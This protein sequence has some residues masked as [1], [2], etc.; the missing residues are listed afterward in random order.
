MGLYKRAHIRGMV[1]ELMRQEIVSFPSKEAADDAADRIADDFEEEEIP[2]VSGE[3]GLSPEQAQ[4]A[5][6]RIVEVAEEIAEKTSGAVDKELNKT[7]AATSY[8]DAAANAGWALIEKAAEETGVATGPD[9][10]GQTAPAPDLGA[11]AEAKQDAANV[12]SADLVGPQGTSDVDTRPGAVGAEEEQ[13]EQPGAQESQPTGEVAK[14]SGESTP[15]ELESLDSMLQKMAAETLKGNKE[16]MDGASLTGG[17]TKGTPPTP[18]Q[19]LDD[20]L[21]I[22]GAV[23]S[24]QGQTGQDVPAAANIGATMKQPAGTPGVTAPTPNKPAK[25]AMKQAMAILNTSETGRAFLRKLSEEAPKTE[26]TEEEKKEM[27]EKKKEDEK[28]EAHVATALQALAQ[29]VAL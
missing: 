14:T 9:I 1:D 3:N 2:E 5:L 29:A 4:A 8:E 24:S 16:A 28:K 11:T 21:N 6:D 18:R 27:E 19:D 25:D 7:A 10:P 23:A 22:P 17:E 13:P 12:P 26:Y 15:S 20:N